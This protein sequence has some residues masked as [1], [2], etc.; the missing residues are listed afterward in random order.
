MHPTVVDRYYD[1][2]EL[3]SNPGVSYLHHPSGVTV[4]VSNEKFSCEVVEVSFGSHKK[5]GVDRTEQT[6]SEGGKKGA[7][8]LQAETR[9]CMLKLAD[10]T[11]RIIRSGVRGF[12]AEVNNTLRESPDLV[13]TAPENQGYLAILTY[14]PGQRK[15]Q[16][17]A[18]I[19]PVNRPSIF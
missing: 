4:L 19:E 5:P 7:L 3:E 15:P 6:R 18:K 16:E 10:G 9:L 2:F 12:L 8:R 13:R 11:E 14:A 1:R 17:L